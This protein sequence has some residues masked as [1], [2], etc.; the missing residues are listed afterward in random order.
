MTP[1]PHAL[2]IAFSYALWPVLMLGAIAALDWRRTTDD[3]FLALNLVYLG[4][5]LAIFALERV[6]PHERAW[7][8]GDGQLGADVGHTLLTKGFVQILLTA[9][10]LTGVAQ[11]AS[12]EPG[13]I[14]PAHWPLWAQVALGLVIAEFGLY[15]A[16]RLAH[17]WPPLWRFHAVHHSV[18]RLWVVNTGRFHFVDTL[19][20]LLFAIP[21]LILAGAPAQVIEWGAALHAFIGLLTH[22]NIEMRFGP[23]SRVF[24]TPGLHRWHHSMR[25]E[26]GNRNYGENLVLWDMVFG[27]WHNPARRPP[28][29]IG[30][31]EPMP[32]DFLGQLAEPFRRADAQPRGR[33]GDAESAR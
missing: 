29:A 8:R 6:M 33:D 30:V 7:L 1:A 2:R 9:L 12:A 31:R 23:I 14:W 26:E 17:E 5:G 10:T 32:N 27:T 11:A 18:R 16:H 13:P 20:S 21:L 19:V 25:L 22:C 28:E 15:W 3:P 24:N 4:L